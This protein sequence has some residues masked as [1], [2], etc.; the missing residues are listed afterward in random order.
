MANCAAGRPFWFQLSAF[1][2]S[3][4]ARVW[5]W[6]ACAFSRLYFCFLLSAFCFCLAVA[7]PG[8]SRFEVQG[9]RFRVRHKHPK[10]N[11]PLPPPPGWSGGTLVPPWTYPGTI[12]PLPALLFDQARLFR[13]VSSGISVAQPYL[14]LDVGCWMLD[15]QCWMFGFPRS[16]VAIRS[17]PSVAGPPQICVIFTHLPRVV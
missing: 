5:L 16:P 17:W 13:S 14:G 10:Y 9:S 12:D 8:C 7:C 11:A 15:V 1:S 4:F 6:V 2:I 3:A